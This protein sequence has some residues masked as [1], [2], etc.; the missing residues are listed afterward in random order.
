MTLFPR[1]KGL[2]TLTSLISLVS[3]SLIGYSGVAQAASPPRTPPV[4]IQETTHT[5][6][7]TGTSTASTSSFGSQDHFACSQ[8]LGQLRV[9]QPQPRYPGEPVLI[10]AELNS[11]QGWRWY[12]SD[13][14]PIASAA[15]RPQAGLTVTVSDGRLQSSGLLGIDYHAQSQMAAQFSGGLVITSNTTEIQSGTD[16]QSLAATAP[17]RPV[18]HMI[19]LPGLMP[20]TTDQQMFATVLW[21]PPVMGGTIT[22]QYAGQPG[23]TVHLGAAHAL[24]SGWTLHTSQA[25][26]THPTLGVSAA[27]T[28]ARTLAQ[29]QRWL[30]RDQFTG[31]VQVNGHQTPLTLQGTIL[32]WGQEQAGKT[33]TMSD[34]W[35]EVIPSETQGLLTT[36]GQPGYPMFQGRANP[37]EGLTVILRG[38]GG[39]TVAALPNGLTVALAIAA[40]ARAHIGQTIPFTVRIVRNGQPY[41]HQ[42]VQMKTNQG[43]LAWQTVTTNAQGIAHDMLRHAQIGTILLTAQ[44]H[45]LVAQARIQVPAPFPWW[46]ILLL[47]LATALLIGLIIR[48]R[49]AAR[50]A[51]TTL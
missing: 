12:F 48:R 45:A 22:W 1:I 49:R 10:E 15:A 32:P 24:P 25:V 26:A 46:L 33:F 3:V 21:V 17:F 9:W 8:G 19:H 20:T 16:Q 47:A 42:Q 36:F 28:G 18:G 40:P 39:Q 29:A 5:L 11:G 37:T 41:A 30:T 43:Q 38:P 14:L 34:H 44:H 13:S 6:C 51:Q 50:R 2:M 4:T 7:L 31:T 35:H 23:G 27:I